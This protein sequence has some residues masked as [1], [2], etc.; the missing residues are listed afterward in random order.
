MGWVLVG[1]TGVAT[2][3]SARVGCGCRDSAV[4]ERE[5]RSEGGDRPS[6]KPA[7]RR[8]DTG[9]RSDFRFGDEGSGMGGTVDVVAVE[10]LFG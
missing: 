6:S 9:V 1:W 10:A 8:G 7:R 2:G 3:V 5:R 4:C